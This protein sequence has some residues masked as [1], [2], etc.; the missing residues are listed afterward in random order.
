MAVQ[1]E[2]SFM[3]IRELIQ[4]KEPDVV[5][6]EFVFGAD[7]TESGDKELHVLLILVQNK[8]SCLVGRIFQ[9]GMM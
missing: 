2:R 1:R 5:P 4:D 9:L 6:G 3:F 7:V 8:K